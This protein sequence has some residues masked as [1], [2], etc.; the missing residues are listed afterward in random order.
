MVLVAAVLLMPAVQSVRMIASVRSHSVRD[1]ATDWI[2]RHV[3]A[4]TRVYLSGVYDLHPPLP[5]PQAADAIWGEL[6]SPDA[7]RRKLGRGLGN[8]GLS[9]DYVP[10]ALSEENLALD[11]SNF[12]R[13][14]ILGS[15]P[16][17]ARPRY[18]LRVY[19]GSPMFG[20]Q[21]VEREFREHGGVLLWRFPAWPMPKQCGEP[22]IQ[23]LND[24]GSGVAIFCSPDLKPKLKAMPP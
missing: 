21:D 14:F 16:D 13:F 1:E 10:R 24:R 17:V 20:V 7:Y 11:R 6:I 3:P 12:R 8:F 15:M 18:D 2:E 4:A 22:V 19:G 9:S 23:W 5:T